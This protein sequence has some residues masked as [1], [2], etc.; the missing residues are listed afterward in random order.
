MARAGAP[1]RFSQE[2]QRLAEQLRADTTGVWGY[3]RVST[4]KQE[5]GESPEFQEKAIR[6]YAQRYKLGEPNIVVESASAGKPL[7]SVTLPGMRESR[8]EPVAAPRP[9]LLALLAHLLERPS[10]HIVVWK[11]DRF[12]R[13]AYEQEMLL[14][15]FQRHDV[16]IHSTMASERELLKD[17]GKVDPARALF[18]TLMGA[19]AQYER[20]IIALRTRTG[21]HMKAARGGWVGG[22]VPYGYRRSEAH[23]LAVDAD[24]AEVV[25]W[26]FYW[27]DPSIML[28][29]D[30]IRE[31]LE[32]RGLGKWNKTK[33]HR[34]VSSRELY[35][36]VYVDPFTEQPHE[37][38]DL[39]ILPETQA[40]WTTWKER[41]HLLGDEEVTEGMPAYGEDLKA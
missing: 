1:T 4:D 25:R 18:R 23:D 3:V 9:L 28:S 17:D 16:S 12:S 14:E 5:D 38:P 39:R 26:I 33:V 40:E 2:Q 41:N 32:Q 27:R 30:K 37:R 19:V 10:Q 24:E 34:I 31:R 11:L 15:M 6:E 22:G 36:G 13:I 7:I 35:E 20:A 29:F 21:M 8:A